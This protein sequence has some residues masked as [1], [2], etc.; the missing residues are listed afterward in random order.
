[1]TKARAPDDTTPTQEEIARARAQGPF[2]SNLTTSEL[3]PYSS[4]L[5]ATQAM[6]AHWRRTMSAYHLPALA[7]ALRELLRFVRMGDLPAFGRD[8]SLRSKHITRINPDT[9]A[10]TD[11][12]LDIDGNITLHGSISLHSSVTLFTAVVFPA[13]DID[14][15]LPLMG[16]SKPL[17]PVTP[18][19][20]KVPYSHSGLA[21]WFQAREASWPSGTPFPNRP[22]DLEA[23]LDHFDRV[24][25][26]EFRRIRQ[27]ATSP[28]WRARGPRARKP[29]TQ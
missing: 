22:T 8:E 16:Q 13:A 18:N 27:G 11:V 28:S 4:P 19:S 12:R 17:V 14:R 23:A 1:M 15:L 25:E 21:D 9:L 29:D 26:K 6:M 7:D 20:G 24:P 5:R 10:A 2:M 3:L